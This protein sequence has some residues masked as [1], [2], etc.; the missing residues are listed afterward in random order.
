MPQKGVMEVELFDVWGIDFMGPFPSSFGKEYILVAVD[1]VSKWVEAI[2]TQKADGKTVL[3]FLKSNIFTRF[4]TPRAIVSDGGSHF[5]NKQFEVLLKKYGVKHRITTAYHPQANGLAE[6]SNREIKQILEKTIGSS[7][8]DWST[9]LEDALW[10]YRTAYKAPL[11]MSPY[12]LVFG[13]ACH[14][15]VELEHKAYWATRTLNLDPTLSGRNRLLQLHALDE[16]R[17]DAY[18]SAK[19]Y[20]E[21]TKAWHDKHILRKDFRVGEEVLLFNSR[22]KLF[23]GKLKSRWSGPFTISK[24]FSSGAVELDDGK[25]KFVVNGQR[26]KK[27]WHGGDFSSHTMQLSPE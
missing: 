5:C 22:L 24:V 11:G 13:K 27:Y 12:R 10:A 23:P 26:V 16:F 2:A 6:L 21:K 9:K 17:H 8:K 19:L 15:P 1:Y 7:R 18:E 14:L 4:G 20:K 3:K 25:L